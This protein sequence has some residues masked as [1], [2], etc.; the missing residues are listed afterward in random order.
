MSPTRRLNNASTKQV[1]ADVAKTVRE[2]GEGDVVVIN[3][4]GRTWLVTDVAEVSVADDDTDRR[5]K[6]AVRMQSHRGT[7]PDAATVALVLVSYPGHKEAAVHVLDAAN[8]LEEDSVYAVDHV[9][10]LDPEPTWVVVQRAGTTDAFHLPAP[11]PAARGDALPACGGRPGD[12]DPEEYRLVSRT[13]I[14]PGPQICRDCARRQRPRELETVACP[15]CERNIAS[16]LFQGP[17]VQGVTGL[18][19]ECPESD[20]SFTGLVD[21]PTVSSD[22]DG[23]PEGGVA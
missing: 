10:I 7:E 15:D 20:C 5:E 6:R 11:V 4:D 14:T 19:V 3:R 13:V 9:E 1:S 22:S 23:G 16:G 21:L 8:R 17:R 12:V 18:R 2:I